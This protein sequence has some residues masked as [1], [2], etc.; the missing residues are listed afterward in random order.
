MT[1][2]AILDYMDRINSALGLDQLETVAEELRRAKILPGVYEGMLLETLS[3]RTRNQWLLGRFL[4][5]IDRH[6]NHLITP[7]LNMA[8]KFVAA[9]YNERPDAEP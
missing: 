1:N 2:T 8:I 7:C 9:D 6:E 5:F 4:L 3:E